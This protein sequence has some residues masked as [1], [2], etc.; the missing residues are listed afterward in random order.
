MCVWVCV[1]VCGVGALKVAWQLI[2]SWITDT[3][4]LWLCMVDSEAV[5]G[6]LI[7]HTHAV[8]EL[9]MHRLQGV[10]ATPVISSTQS[11]TS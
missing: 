2:R 5:C 4:P 7:A 8:H 3:L 6:G 9:T 1:C 10:S 11:S